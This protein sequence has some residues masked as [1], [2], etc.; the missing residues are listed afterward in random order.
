MKYSVVIPVYNGEKTLKT[1]LI[2]L[3]NQTV[4]RNEYEVIVVDDG[5]TDSSGKLAK[6]GA[7]HYFYQENQGPAAARNL[8]AQKAAGDYILFT[9]S[10]CEPTEQWLEQMVRPFKDNADIVGVKGA[11]LSKQK[12]IMARFVQIEYESRYEFMKKY[13]YI[14]FIDTY[15]AA[16]KKDIFLQFNGFDSDFPIAMTEDT[17]LS[18]RI[19][20]AGHKMVFNPDA[21]VYHHH[22]TSFSYYMKRK[23]RAAYWRMLAVKKNRDKIKGDTHTPNDI[24]CQ[25]LSLPVVFFGII[26]M[27]ASGNI[28]VLFVGI[29]LFLMS[30]YAFMRHA[31]MKD[32]LVSILSPFII[33]A[34]TIAYTTGLSLGVWRFLLKH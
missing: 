33:G 24:K 17:E 27:A 29:L 12:E 32:H 6:A 26:V 9:D 4:S 15:A 8:G 25:I 28:S 23:Y 21:I 18:Y 34:R 31:M 16:Y 3:E 1:C 22:P 7:N 11:Y 19:A 10:D 14:D 5:S 2:A 20:A 13:E 30:C